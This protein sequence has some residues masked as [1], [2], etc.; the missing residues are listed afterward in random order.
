ML[1]LPPAHLP[2]IES[3]FEGIGLGTVAKDKNRAVIF[4]NPAAANIIGMKKARQLL[5]QQTR[6]SSG[7]LENLR[8]IDE[9]WFGVIKLPP[10][11]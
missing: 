2:A 9:F 5:W 1:N 11:R 3:V 6:R 10:M 8:N 4:A 7:A